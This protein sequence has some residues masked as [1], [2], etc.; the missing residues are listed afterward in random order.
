MKASPDLEYRLGKRFAARRG[1]FNNHQPWP[2]GAPGG[3]LDVKPSLEFI[4]RLL[5]STGAFRFGQ[6]NE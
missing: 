6:N 4:A 2:N 1:R 3:A 5:I